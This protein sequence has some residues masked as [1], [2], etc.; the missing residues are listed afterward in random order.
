MTT[1]RVECTDA[2]HEVTA[3]RDDR[4]RLVTRALLHVEMRHPERMDERIAV[5]TYA[6]GCGWPVVSVLAPGEMTRVELAAEVAAS[7]SRFSHILARDDTPW[8]LETTLQTL[9]DAADHLMRDHD[10]DAHGHEQ[11]IEAVASARAMLGGR[12]KR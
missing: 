2:V 11:V 1:W 7:R 9:A 3:L 8:S 4:R 10:C 6:V 12:E 5:A